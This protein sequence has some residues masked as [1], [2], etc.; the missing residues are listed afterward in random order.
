MRRNPFA[1]LF[2]VVFATLSWGTG[3]AQAPPREIVPFPDFVS[4]VAAADAQAWLARPESR[5]TTPA[6]FEEM[7]QHILSLYRGVQ[8]THSFA[9]DS[10]IFDCIPI[11]QQ[12]S[13]RLLGQQ[14]IVTPPPP[15]A[16]AP[17]PRWQVSPGSA[18]PLK[19]PLEL[20]RVDPFGNAVSCETGTIPMRRVTLEEISRFGSLREFFQK[21]PA[22]A[23]RPHVANEPPAAL[24]ATHKYAHA[25]QFVNNHGG[26]SWLNLWSPAINQGA[27]QIFSLSQHWYVGGS[28]ASLQTVEG[29]WQDYPAKYGTNNS[30]TFIYWTADDYSSTGCYNLDCAAFVQTNSN[31]PLGGAWSIYSTP[32]GTQ[33]EFQLQW[34]L[35]QGNWWLFLQGNGTFDAVGYY[36]GSIYRGG[37]LSQY[38]TEIDYG[39][40]TVGTTSWPPMG[41]GAFA[42]AG[43]QQAAYQRAIFYTDMADN[44]QWSSLN[45]SQPSPT[46]YTLIFTPSSSGGSWGSY[47]FF[48]G[49]GGNNC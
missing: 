42:S 36:P 19:S 23:G 48:G 6:A 9:L 30:V 41:S 35:Y 46:C 45:T 37:Q 26:D 3:F 25:Y 8:A 13:V 1:I 49:P 38:A 4:G 20:G 7:R 2:T 31:W 29:G 22:G 24:T 11:A 44:G 16:L 10:Q 28:G 12:P 34:K 32:G 47:F 15:P 18:E 27:S 33:Y 21:G 5:V 39:G 40:E 17:T 43:W 14:T